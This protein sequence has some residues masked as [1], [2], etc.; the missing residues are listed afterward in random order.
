MYAHACER[1]KDM[2]KND[3]SDLPFGRVRSATAM[4]APMNSTSST[5][6]NHRSQLGACLLLRHKLMRVQVRV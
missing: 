2:S 1:E 5:I 4:N 6:S 3:M